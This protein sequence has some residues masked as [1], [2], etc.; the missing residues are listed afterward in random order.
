MKSC[1]TAYEVFKLAFQNGK[2]KLIR[3]VQQYIPITVL[4][5]DMLLN[6]N[7][8]SKRLLDPGRLT[9]SDVLKLAKLSDIEATELFSL[10]K[11]E[12]LRT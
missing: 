9:L 5:Q 10:T 3:E 7:T 12:I 2:V 6:Y 11:K 1:A 8:L 4:C